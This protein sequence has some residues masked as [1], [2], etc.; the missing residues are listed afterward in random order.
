MKQNRNLHQP[1]YFDDLVSQTKAF[2]HEYKIDKQFTVE[3]Y[4]LDKDTWPTTSIPHAGEK[5]VYAFL[6]DSQRVLYIGKASMNNTLGARIAS[7]F[8]SKPEFRSK[9]EWSE[10]LRTVAIIAVTDG[11]QAAALEEFLIWNLNPPDNTRGKRAVRPDR[12]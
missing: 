5:G 4:K 11:P 9:F 10:P 3:I 1:K 6:S 2:C 8:V 7:Y 12:E